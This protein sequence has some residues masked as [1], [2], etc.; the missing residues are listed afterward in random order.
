MATITVRRRA[1]AILKILADQARKQDTSGT[2]YLTR[3][4]IATRLRLEY[5]EP[6]AHYQ[7]ISRDQEPELVAAGLCRQVGKASHSRLH[8]TKIGLSIVD[9][10]S[11]LPDYI[12]VSITSDTLAFDFAGK[13][14]IRPRPEWLE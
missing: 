4:E 5:D 7:S 10:L 9:F 2:P 11:P 6:Y 12:T 3:F 14:H 8:I 13:F 1:L